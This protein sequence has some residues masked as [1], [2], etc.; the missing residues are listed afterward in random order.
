MK[1]EFE[2]FPTVSKTCEMLGWKL[3]PFNT[4]VIQHLGQADHG[5]WEA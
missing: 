4:P 1:K 3:Q 5:P 2:L